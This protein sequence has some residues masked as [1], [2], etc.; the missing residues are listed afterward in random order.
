MDIRFKHP[1]LSDGDVDVEAL[2]RRAALLP[3]VNSRARA[4]LCVLV[5]LVFYVL[6]RYHDF[7]RWA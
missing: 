7:I 3:K 2:D 6:K 5:V 1:S 4:M